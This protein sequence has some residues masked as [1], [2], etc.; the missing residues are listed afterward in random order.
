MLIGTLVTIA[1]FVPIG[2]AQSGAGE[3]TFS[4]F[5]VVAISLIIS[6]LVAVVFG[7][8]LGKALRKPP[9]KRRPQ[10][11]QGWC[12]GYRSFLRPRCASAG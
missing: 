2:F 1:A 11:G 8:L 6:W 12:A 4:I 10:A 7:P 9:K 3:Y 5:S